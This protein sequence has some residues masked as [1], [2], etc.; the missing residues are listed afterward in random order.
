MGLSWGLQAAAFEAGKGVQL[1]RSGC[2]RILPPQVPCTP[3]MTDQQRW[4]QHAHPRP[5]KEALAAWPLC[6]FHSSSSQ[7]RHTSN[8]PTCT[9]PRPPQ[10][11]A[12]VLLRG[13]SGSWPHR[14][15]TYRQHTEAAAA[16]AA[17]AAHAC[18]QHTL[19]A[20]HTGAGSCKHMV[21]MAADCQTAAAGQL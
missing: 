21:P 7:Q 8:R 12:G 18:M 2:T 17:A 15:A 14:R 20:Q 9:A 13:P 4:Q 10:P 3:R 16:A 5:S 19:H 11:P 1:I 6:D